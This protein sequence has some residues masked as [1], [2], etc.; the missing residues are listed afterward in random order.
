MPLD[1]PVLTVV[2][3]AHAAYAGRS[4]AQLPAEFLEVVD[5]ALK[6]EAGRA[7]RIT[8]FV[9][10]MPAQGETLSREPGS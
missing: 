10:N 2:D 6:T 3:A 9:D 1:M 8:A 5:T 4:T 7:K